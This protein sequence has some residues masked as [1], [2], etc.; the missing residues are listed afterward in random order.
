[1]K[2]QT[3]KPQTNP[4]RKPTGSAPISGAVD[5]KLEALEKE[6]D[7]TGNRSKVIAYKKSLK[8]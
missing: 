8:K 5:S 4:E 2:V 6:A 1:M 7:R 3:R